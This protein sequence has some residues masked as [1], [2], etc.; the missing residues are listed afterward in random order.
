MQL[1]TSVILPSSVCSHTRPEAAWL[2][3]MPSGLEKSLSAVRPDTLM[4]F[5]M[6]EREPNRYTSHLKVV[7]VGSRLSS[8]NRT[9]WPLGLPRWAV[10]AAPLGSL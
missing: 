3:H 6:V 1:V 7:A 9:T 5:A 2:N 8:A 4:S 10:L